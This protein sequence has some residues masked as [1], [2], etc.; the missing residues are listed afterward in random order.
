MA[1]LVDRLAHLGPVIE[2]HS[3]WVFLGE[4]F[5]IKTK[6]PVDLGFL[7]FSTLSRRKSMCDAEVGLNQRLAPGVYLGVVPILEKDGETFVDDESIDP[8]RP[9]DTQGAK[10]VDYGVKM[11]RLSDGHRADHL[12]QRGALEPSFADRVAETLAAFHHRC[13]SDPSMAHHGSHEAISR[14]VSDNFVQS[15]PLLSDLSEYVDAA[16]S[17]Q[18][19]FLETH[20]ELLTHRTNN[21]FVRDGHGDLRLEHL[22]LEGD[23]L[24]IIDCIE[25]NDGFRYADVVSDLSF[26]TMDLR[27]QSQP[28]VA[29]RLLGSYV[30]R[31]R[32]FELYRLVDFY[33]SY[34]AFVRAK[35]TAILRSQM[36]S[37]A[38]TASMDAEIA[39]FCEQSAAPV[40]GKGSERRLILV[41]GMIASGKTTVSERL[42]T[43][44]VPIVI[45][46]DTTRK[47]LHGVRPDQQCHEPAF[48][49]MYS[50]EQSARV[51]EKMMSDASF[52]L[53]SGRSVIVEASFSKRQSRALF[54][55]LA[56]AFDAELHFIECRAPEAATFERLERREG[57][58]GVSDG[59]R[60]IYESFSQGYEPIGEG[61][62]ERHLVLRTERSV[63]QQ[64]EEL[65]AFL[66][67]VD[68]G[69]NRPH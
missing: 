48:Q 67:F 49:G 4:R 16:E 33:E 51:Y 10:L 17:Y 19:S 65:E 47:H 38:D 53:G 8:R 42:R 30:R 58:G 18:R 22:Y 15:R 31:T 52:V 54:A 57:A 59:R 34:R 12:L 32:D 9:S 13:P 21:G 36:D 29:E 41:G 55:Q 2:T 26:L 64:R 61:E 66:P 25:F 23:E 44:G 62:F 45:D 35:V 24:F 50:P 40:L 69:E 1:S 46:S 37:G 5:V 11:R 20:N 43:S 27:H 28:G 3:A 14:Q 68:M 60:E 63:E 56:A 39:R 7:D 6:K